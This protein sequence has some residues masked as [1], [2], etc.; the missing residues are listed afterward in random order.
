MEPQ[1]ADNDIAISYQQVTKSYG[2]QKVLQGI[3][4][5]VKKGEFLGLVGANGAGKTT[6]IKSLLDFIE[7]DSGTILIAE[8]DN[9]NPQAREH[10]AFLP[11]RF[12]PPYFFKGND[13]LKFTSQIHG[14]EFDDSRVIILCE[15]L[16]LAKEALNKPVRS[17]SKG[18]AQKLGLMGCFLAEKP[19][20]ILDEPMSGLDPKARAYLKK[21]IKSLKETQTTLF[22]ST[23]MLADVDVICDRMA[24]LDQ[25]VIKFVG[26]TDECREKFGSDDLEQAYLNCISN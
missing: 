23:H 16:D 15:N 3:S 5:E 6:M 25:G 7:P 13:F 24:I 11:E 26:T 20:V 2:K 12:N 21:Q 14:V 4:L 19:V 8:N 9:Q 10:L 1:Q 18:M 17:Y 22:F